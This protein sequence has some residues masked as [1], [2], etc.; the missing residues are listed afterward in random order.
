[1][2][3]NAHSKLAVTRETLYPLTTPL[4]LV[5]GGDVIVV[6]PDSSRQC[7]NVCPTPNSGTCI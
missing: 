4:R 1:M 7:S 3:K 2:R 5:Q 6:P